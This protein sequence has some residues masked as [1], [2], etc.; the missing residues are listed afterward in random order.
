MASCAET[1]PVFVFVLNYEYGGRGDAE[2]QLVL[3][4]A[5]HFAA[6]S[7]AQFVKGCGKKQLYHLNRVHLCPVQH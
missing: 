3:A 4:S 1:K 2:V 6:Q 7:A 5:Q